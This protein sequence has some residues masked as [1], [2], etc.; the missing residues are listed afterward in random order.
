[1]AATDGDLPTIP[2]GYFHSTDSTH[3]SWRNDFNNI[4]EIGKGKVGGHAGG[5]WPPEEQHQPPLHP[6]P[7]YPSGHPRH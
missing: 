4:A 2:S 1:M 6:P 5:E 7:R 3:W